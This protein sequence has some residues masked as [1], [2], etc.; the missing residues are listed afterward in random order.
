[1][2]HV[3]ASRAYRFLMILHTVD[4]ED[5]ILPLLVQLQLI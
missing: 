2:K 3:A 4:L 1:V 5:C